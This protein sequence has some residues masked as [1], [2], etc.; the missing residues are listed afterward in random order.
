MC[1]KYNCHF[2]PDAE[3][4]VYPH[5]EV[6][7]STRSNLTYTEVRCQQRLP[8]PSAEGL[9][10]MNVGCLVRLSR[11]TWDNTEFKRVVEIRN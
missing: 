5:C 1:T 10:M 4:N 9:A 7:W 11:I 8:R 3:S 2:V 6:T